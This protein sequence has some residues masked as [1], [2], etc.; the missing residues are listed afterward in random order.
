M[1][2]DYPRPSKANALS[3]LKKNIPITSVIDVG[4]REKTGELINIFPDIKHH[5][6]EPVSEFFETIAANYKSVPHKLYPMALSDECGL[7]YLVIRSL[8]KNG[9]PTHSHISDRAVVVDG[10]HII[11]CYSIDVRRFD[12]LS[13]SG[14]LQDNFLLKVDVDG[15][16]LNVLKGF[17][18]ALNKASAVIVECTAEN[19]LE[20]IGYVENAGFLI[21]DLVDI[22]YY[23]DSL[24]Q[25]DAVMVRKDLINIELK[26][27]LDPFNME[28]WNPLTYD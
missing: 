23:G 17:G 12:S 3:R 21:T 7:L 19:I 22:V 16:D 18:Q 28:L 5:L 14:E 27:S 1:K 6:F 10:T 15:K 13:L 4:V 8:E 9:Q 24:Y 2:F 26:P 20:R 25:L 11:N